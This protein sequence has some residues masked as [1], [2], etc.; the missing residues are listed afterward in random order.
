MEYP[1]NGTRNG[2]MVSIVDGL[3]LNDVTSFT[4]ACQQEADGMTMSFRFPSQME[5]TQLAVFD[6]KRQSMCS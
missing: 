3:S 2:S 6:F 5:G 1:L 4:P